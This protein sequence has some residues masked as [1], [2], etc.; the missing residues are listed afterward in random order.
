MG[1]EEEG[2]ILSKYSD[3][4][5]DTIKQKQKKNAENNEK[6]TIKLR[7]HGKNSI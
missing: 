1:W 5:M 3:V 6:E 2:D 4:T 7:L